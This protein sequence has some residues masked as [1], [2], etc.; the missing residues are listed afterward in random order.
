MD[1]GIGPT[2]F[3]VVQVGLRFR[4]TFKAHAFERRPLGVA[5]AALDL[6]FPI[7]I[8]DT[9]RQSDGPVVRQHITVQRVSVG[10]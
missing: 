4:Q 7:R 10:S 5:D 8:P 9:A 2:L 3:P 6:P 1:A